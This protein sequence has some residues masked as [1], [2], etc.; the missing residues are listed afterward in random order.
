MITARKLVLV[1]SVGYSSPREKT[2]FS[3]SAGWTVC[4]NVTCNILRILCD[5]LFDRWV[6]PIKI[7]DAS[8]NVYFHAVITW[9]SRV[10][11][12]QGDSSISKLRL[13]SFIW[14]SSL[15]VNRQISS[16][17]F[18]NIKVKIKIFVMSI[19][20]TFVPAHNIGK[21][22]SSRQV[23]STYL[24]LGWQLNVWFP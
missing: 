6:N 1:N 12:L 4:E 10:T 7:K 21:D 14:P 20:L 24:F 19:S 8:C 18:Q 13:P 23:K 16:H 17:Q 22:K 2:S 9:V 5:S 15:L 3:P 11:W